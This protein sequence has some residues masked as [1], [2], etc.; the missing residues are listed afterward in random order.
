VKSADSFAATDFR[1]RI[2]T[3]IGAIHYGQIH[4]L[5]HLGIGNKIVCWQTTC[6][7]TTARPGDLM[8][9]TSEDDEAVA[10][11][12][13]WIGND[14]VAVSGDAPYTAIHELKYAAYFFQSEQFQVRRSST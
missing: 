12:V 9:P 4:A 5:W 3:G 8:L 11:A 1:K 14:E 6:F 7:E 10:K 2:E 13:A